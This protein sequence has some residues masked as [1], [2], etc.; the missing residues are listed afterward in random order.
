MSF[1]IFST[2]FIFAI[3]TISGLSLGLPFAAYIFFAASSKNASAPRPYTVSV[4]N[5]TS[6]PDFNISAA[7]FIVSS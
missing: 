2:S 3:C 1:A 6:P 4:G 7:N 5:A